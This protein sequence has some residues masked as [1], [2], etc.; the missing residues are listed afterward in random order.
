M[1]L[2]YLH[3]HLSEPAAEHVIANR[4][5]RSGKQSILIIELNKRDCFAT[6]AKTA[7]GSTS[8]DCKFISIDS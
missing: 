7:P 2:R 3:L 8:K 4:E 1:T 6:L 5:E